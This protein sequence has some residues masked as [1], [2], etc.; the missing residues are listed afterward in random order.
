MV[1]LV[2]LRERPQHL[3]TI[4]GWIH[5]QWWSNTDTPPDAIERWLGS[6][7]G[8]KGFPTTLVAIEDGEAVASVCLHETE[9][10]D[11]PDYKPYLGALFVTP[12]S[13]GRGLGVALV[14]AIEAQGRGL[15]FRE[16]YLN[17]AD[18]LVDFYEVL[19]WVVVE[20]SYGPKC[21]NILRR[22]LGEKDGA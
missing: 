6:H 4:A 19:G 18:P 21:L 10:M 15:G 11:R 1:Q 20:R 14:R 5:D 16:M 13:R 7:L 2:S 22:E 3:K 12:S 17:A 9:A 8:Q